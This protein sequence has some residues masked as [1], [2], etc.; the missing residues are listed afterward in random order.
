MPANLVGR[1]NDKAL[2]MVARQ[3]REGAQA[4]AL[5]RA[6]PRPSLW[7]Q[8]EGPASRAT[9]AAAAA[10]I[11]LA[12]QPSVTMGIEKTRDQVQPLAQIH[13]ERHIADDGLLA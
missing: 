3:L 12:L 8:I 7:S 10:A 13:H 9:A 2:R 11:L 5:R 1:A 4:E 6:K